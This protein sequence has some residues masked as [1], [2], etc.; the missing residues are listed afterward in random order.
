MKDQS[1]DFRNKKMCEKILKSMISAD[2]LAI[3]QQ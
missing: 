2:K 1:F 3:K